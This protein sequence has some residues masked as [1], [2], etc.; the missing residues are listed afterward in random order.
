MCEVQ[1]LNCE[2][3]K[4]LLPLYGEDLVSEVSRE[5]VETHLQ[6]CRMCEELYRQMRE[7][8]FTAQMPEVLEA[9]VKPLKK[10]KRMANLRTLLVSLTAVL[11]AA[12]LFWGLFV[13]MVPIKAEDLKVTYTAE[14]NTEAKENSSTHFIEFTIENTN[15]KALSIREKNMDS[16]R[17]GRYYMTAY[18]IFRMPFDDLGSSESIGVSCIGPFSEDAVF[19]IKCRDKTITYSLK[20]IAE[21]C[22]IQ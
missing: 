16:Q 19:E 5:A 22:G 10:I 14:I 11:A 8:L 9:E 1:K 7:E 13:G 21:E 6:S 17:T 12:L 2:I 20:E 15:G 4:D 18:S 3:V